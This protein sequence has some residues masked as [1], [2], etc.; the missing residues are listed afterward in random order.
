VAAGPWPQRA[1]LR[2]LLALA[3]RPRGAALLAWAAPLDQVLRGLR[4]VGRYDDPDVA[5]GLGWDAE[6]VVARGREL[7]RSEGRP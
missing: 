3:G 7:R 6:A 5:R 4:T 1:V 2:A